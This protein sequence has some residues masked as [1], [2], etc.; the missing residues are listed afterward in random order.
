MSF[1]PLTKLNI[2]LLALTITVVFMPALSFANSALV[3]DEFQ[4]GETGASNE[5][6]VVIANYYDSD[7]NLTGYS[8]IRKNNDGSTISNLY[9]FPKSAN[10]YIKKGQKLKFANKSYTGLFDFR[11]SNS[12]S[13]ISTDDTLV[14]KNGDNIIDRVGFN[15]AEEYEGNPIP[16]VRADAYYVR[17]E[18]VDTDNN[19]ND[20]ESSVKVVPII[21]DQ[22][23]NKLVI[24]ELLPSPKSGEEWFELYNPTNLDISLANLKICD[25]LG[26]THY[27]SFDE[28][29]YLPA[30]SYKTYAQSLTK[31][32]LNNNGDFLELYDISDNLIT[33]S[34]GDYGDSD[35]GI[36]LALF[37]SEYRWTK[38]VTRAGENV[39]VDIIEIEEEPV[40]KPKTTKSKVVKAIKKTTTAS[41]SIDNETVLD[42][43]AEVKAAKTVSPAD[44]VQ[45]VIVN[46]KVLGWGL[47]GLAILLVL[48]YTLWYFRDYAKNIYDKIKRRD[49]SARF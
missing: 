37:G 27:Y 4:I 23:A 44:T 25:V 21:I 18:G 30:N 28:E 16:I 40:A 2:S 6:Y 31:I 39:F 5:D 26:S 35:K 17:S 46:N 14:L 1:M 29:D 13:Y 43:E 41:T 48:G 20:F 49:D 22:N 8:L 24:S 12:S 45:K 9:I 3:I 32:T 36:S 15:N 11:Y 47:I 10:F 34:G 33:D 7:I 19:E 42:D 38:A